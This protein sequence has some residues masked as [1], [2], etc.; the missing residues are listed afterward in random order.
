MMS[1][2]LWLAG[3]IVAMGCLAGCGTGHDDL[4]PPEPPK[5][6]VAAPLSR[7]IRDDDE[8]TGRIEARET[9]EVRARVSGYLQ[10]IYFKDGDF[11]KKDQPL[12]L[13]DPR[14]YQADLDQAKA[15]INLYD[16]KYGYAK[17][18]RARSEKLVQNNSVSR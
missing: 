9:V 4:P 10:E 5:V 1:Q 8:Y 11:V 12:F 13:I 18:V 6:T 2:R 15:K 7:E 3:A 17:S 14:T 16:A